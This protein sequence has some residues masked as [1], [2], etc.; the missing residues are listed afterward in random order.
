MCLGLD[1]SRFTSAVY[2]QTGL[3][4]E[5]KGFGKTAQLQE[6]REISSSRVEESMLLKHQ[7]AALTGNQRDCLD[8][9]VVCVEGE[10]PGLQDGPR[11]LQLLDSELYG[12]KAEGDG[13]KSLRLA[14]TVVKTKY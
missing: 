7:K 13:A 9:H 8:I 11:R 2:Q 5:A 3:S 10:M 1:G 12:P 4:N 6:M 14:D